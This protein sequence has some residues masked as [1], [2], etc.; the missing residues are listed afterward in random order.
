MSQDATKVL[1]GSHG[2]SDLVATKEEGDPATFEAGLAVKRTSSGLSLSSGA[3]I[4]V[5][6][7]A[8]LSDSKKTS[9]ARAGNEI[10]LLCTDEGEFA[11]LVVGD[12]TF[13]AKAKGLAGNDITITLADEVTDASAAV[14]EMSPGDLDIIVDMQDMATTAEDIKAAI[15]VD[16]VASLLVSVEI[17]EGEDTTAQAAAVEDNLEGGLDSYPYVVP[18]VAVEVDSSTGMAVSSGD[19]TGAV[20]LR[21]PLSGVKIDGSIHANGVAIIDMGGGL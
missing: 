3:L 6:L 9:V 18:G 13:T 4:G 20:Y 16:P 10:P 12:L 11:S 19:A 15:D 2:S 1:L 7:G 21:G 17:A 8:D 5:S 14:E